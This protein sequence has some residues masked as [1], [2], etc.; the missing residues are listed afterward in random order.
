MKKLV[1]LLLLIPLVSFGQESI[2]DYDDFN[3][4]DNQALVD[5]YNNPNNDV[6]YNEDFILFIGFIIIGG[7]IFIYVFRPTPSETSSS[8]SKKIKSNTYREAISAEEDWIK[9]GGD[10]KEMMREMAEKH[11]LK[12]ISEKEK[13]EINEKVYDKLTKTQI[14]DRQVYG[15][16]R[17]YAEL[18]KIDGD[19][20]PNE[21][22]II[23][24]LSKKEQEKLSG[25]YSQDSDEFKFVWASEE[26]VF[27]SLKT[28]NK[29]E[30]KSFFD[31]LF[32]VAASDKKI[33]DPEIDF[34]VTMY[35]NITGCDEKESH[36]TVVALFQ[37]WNARLKAG[38]IKP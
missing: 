7:I 34:M 24:A 17:A 35:K 1:L 12:D 5:K 2:E 25:E 10:M 37:N 3:E 30:T 26:N 19:L 18:M 23:G 32:M 21:M 13:K 22:M 20:D 27:T 28:Y 36:E 4:E 15:A 33:K 9:N 16:I 8:F 31:N 14:K 11:A 38:K 29:K 6:T